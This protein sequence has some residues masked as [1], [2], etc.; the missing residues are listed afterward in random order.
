MAD[1]SIIYSKTGKGLRARNAAN[2]DLSTQQLKLLAFINGKSKADEILNQSDTF[3]EKEL[4]ASLSQLETNGFIRPLA[5]AQSTVED[6]GLTSNFTPMVV[7]EFKNEDEIEAKALAKAATKVAQEKQDAERIA[8][9]KAN[10]KIRWMAEINARKE[11][12]AKHKAEEKSKVAAKEKA[13]L[14]QERLVREAAQAKKNKDEEQKKQDDETRAKADAKARIQTDEK[15]RLKAQ[16]LAKAENEAQLEAMR[17]AKAELK[18]QQAAEQTRLEIERLEKIKQAQLEAERIAKAENDAQL[19]TARKA[20]AEL[21]LQQELQQKAQQKA[22]RAKLVAAQART[23][24]AEKETADAATKEAARLEMTRIV[25]KAEEERKQVESQLKEAWLEAKRQFKAK[26]HA[27]A[28]AARKAKDDAAQALVDATAVTQKKAALLE[29]VQIEMNRFTRDAKSEKNIVDTAEN[30]A[31]ALLIPEALQIVD[32]IAK[33]PSLKLA[34]LQALEKAEQIR[35]NNEADEKAALAEKE[36]ARQEIARIAREADALRSQT[37]NP[38]L[39][40]PTKSGR[41]EASN[42][43]QLKSA[44]LKQSTQE[45]QL[46][47]T[48]KNAKNLA[49]ARAREAEKRAYVALTEKQSAAKYQAEIKVPTKTMRTLIDLISIVLN[50]VK[51]LAKLLKTTLIVD[52]ILA[53]LLIGVLHFVNISPLIA[54]IEK[55]ATNNLG[56]PVHIEQVRASLWPQP[57]F[58]LGNVAIGDVLKVTSIQVIPDASTLFKDVKRVKMLQIHG[59]MIEHNNLEQLL[60]V[61]A[62]IGKAPSLKIEQLNVSDL[63]FKAKD[64]VLGPFDGNLTLNAASELTSLDLHHVNQSLTAQIKRL[65]ADQGEDYAITLT[66]NHWPLP[67]NPNIVFDELKA[68]ASLHQNQ[69]TFSQIEGAIFGGNISAQA[70]LDWS[71]GWHTMGNFTLTSAN[72]PQLL[73]A[74][75]SKA[76]VEGKVSLAGDFAS[77]SIE[78]LKL[79]DEPSISANIALKNGKINGVDL[80][81]AVLFNQNA[82]L[83]GEATAFDTLSAHLQ[84]NGGQYHYKQ[85]ALNTKQ[86]H[87]NGNVN[88]DQNRSLT[89]RANASL[90]VQSRRLQANFGLSGTINNVKRQ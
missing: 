85:I 56:S 46:K 6:W 27:R 90:A 40:I 57:H 52:F 74:F 8:A 14:A 22:E 49:D 81:H 7:E 29:A 31:K 87:A 68:K 15:A 65:G 71:N 28:K 42:S 2:A 13:R 43:M 69:M 24:K 67:L 88:I 23:I 26:E 30:N 5:A 41:F 73:S 25:R 58:T 4:A 72:A 16:L 59:L 38:T 18:A 9:E 70:V 47:V 12:E 1:L 64:L 84:V 11:A 79:A 3:T 19:E 20:K 21:I 80:A 54:P 17:K 61:I 53:F 63:S 86:F 44:K 39:T 83:A 77:Q 36:L 76:S 51:W 75:A 60:N 48:E 78:A 37:N 82:S 34:D 50:C 55:L 45:S 33:R 89:G 35:A 62:Q 10:E 66:G 32:K